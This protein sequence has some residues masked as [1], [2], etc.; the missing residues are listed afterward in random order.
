MAAVAKKQYYLVCLFMVFFSACTPKAYTG[1]NIQLEGRIELELSQ[2]EI[3]TVT[4]EQYRLSDNYNVL[5]KRGFTIKFGIIRET[6]PESQPITNHFTGG[7]EY[8][9]EIVF[10]LEK[11]KEIIPLGKF[12]SSAGFLDAFGNSGLYHDQGFVE[13]NFFGFPIESIDS[14]FVLHGIAKLMTPT[15]ELYKTEVMLPLYIDEET[16]TL[17][18]WQFE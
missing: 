14:P 5:K 7:E 16:L 4:P 12:S 1:N 2:Y 10:F 15:R 18:R 17:V 13:N 11:N 3:F 6:L 8:I 9:R